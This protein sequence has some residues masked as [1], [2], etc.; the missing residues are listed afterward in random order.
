MSV[1]QR[2]CS[3][4]YLLLIRP[5]LSHSLFPNCSIVTAASVCF[6]QVSHP[7]LCCSRVN[8]S[9]NH[10]FPSTFNFFTKGASP[11]R[12][13][14]CI[15]TASLSP[16]LMKQGLTAW[17]YVSLLRPWGSDYGQ[18]LNPLMCKHTHS[19][20]HPHPSPYARILS[21]EG[22]ACWSSPTWQ[23]LP[24]R[25]CGMSQTATREVRNI[26]FPALHLFPSLCSTSLT[27]HWRTQLF[28]RRC[29]A[30]MLTPHFL[31]VLAPVSEWE[32]MQSG[33]LVQENENLTNF[34][35]LHSL[36]FLHIWDHSVCNLV[37]IKKLR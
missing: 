37:L 21:G 29:I 6:N 33:V 22:G 10:V 34:P 35:G 13:D 31:I 26:S 3:F 2:S 27:E 28:S 12:V 25:T 14:E 11:R 23:P 8:Q 20:R 24:M 36:L 19:Y 4:G 5:L 15:N 7:A 17:G 30:Q 18:C 1:S 32:E 9:G 16:A